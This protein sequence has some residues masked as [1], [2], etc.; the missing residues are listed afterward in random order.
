MK[1]LK[2]LVLVSFIGCTILQ[3]QQPEKLL[4]LKPQ[5]TEQLVDRV[6]SALAFANI[7]PAQYEYSGQVTATVYLNGQ[8]FES[9][10]FCLF[11]FIDGNVRGIS[12]G[13]WFEPGNKWIHNH[14]IYSNSVEGDTTRFKL[15]DTSSDTWYEFEE[16]VVFKADMLLS[17]AIN[18]FILQNSTLHTPITLNIEPSLI[19]WPN[20]A[21]YQA[22]IRF[23]IPTD[24]PIVIQVIDFTGR[25]V[26]EMKLGNQ[27]QGEHLVDWNTES[28]D[29]GVYSLKLKNT[30]AIYKK[31][32][33]IR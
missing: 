25:V 17:D 3:A 11:S 14:L 1:T 18:P 23:S 22:N 32:V 28:L 12:R 31:V 10:D 16:F 7:N 20:P 24:Q 26:E 9:E 4:K 33:I 2:V 13:M 8:N 30:Q 5:K 6:K 21:K 27:F 15:Y 29:Q 19:V